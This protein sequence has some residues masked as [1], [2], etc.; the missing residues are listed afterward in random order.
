MKRNT[1]KWKI[2]KYNIIVI[3][4][5]I[6]LTTI[7]FNVAVRMYFKKDILRQ[8]NK[9]ASATE[10]T[11]LEH[12]PDFFP[13]PERMPPPRPKNDNGLFKY[14][15][16]IDHS[17]KEP[18]SVLNANVIL[19]DKNKNRITPFQ[20]NSSDISKELMSQFTNEVNKSKT[21][22][23][24]RY[25]NLNLLGTKYIAIIKP[26]FNKN[27]FG[28]GWII[29]YSSLEKIN[30]LQLGINLILFIIL[31][32]SAIVIGIFSSRLSK[33]IS[34]PFSLLNDYISNIAERNF[35]SIVEMPIYDELKD[36][37]VN[38][39]VMSEKL[40]VYDKAQ[41]TFLQNASH[42]FRNPLMSIQSYAEGIK[43][44]VVDKKIAAD[45]IVNE[46]KRMTHL[47]E[48]LLYLSRLDA[49]EEHYYSNSIDINELIS[50]CIR[51]MEVIANKNNIVI[52][53]NVIKKGSMLIGD[54]DKLSR[55][56]GNVISNCIRYA[57]RVV[58]ITVKIVNNKVEIIIGDDGP[59][60]DNKELPNIFER[61]YKG[62]KGNFGLGLSISKN[63]VEKHN[64]KITAQNSELGAL[65]IIELPIL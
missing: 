55:A 12:G 54:E 30:Q 28:L 29:I 20:E 47:V 24:E 37:V 3:V 45:V 42:E 44:D 1:I 27:S 25:L 31:I 59:G 39:N 5:L 58:I 48:D 11:A 57:N 53:N 38:I 60:I 17:L 56:I 43:Y 33:K 32:F 62:K 7:I 51:R 6:T 61:F 35:G 23:S 46:S 40:E 41:K 9:I 15:S 21:F 16:M 64:G 4:M 2:F 18:I 19:L 8:L 36:F 52:N 13:G 65:F 34:D 26:V 22:S 10:D 63:I 50:S 14:Y 49:I